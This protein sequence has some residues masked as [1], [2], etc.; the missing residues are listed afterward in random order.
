MLQK[1]LEQRRESIVTKWIEQLINSYEPE[2]IRFLKREK[3][4][5]ANPVRST[6][7]SSIGKLYDGILSGKNLTE[8]YQGLEEIIKLRAVQ[9][10]SP[11]KAL[12]FLFD[13]KKIVRDE[14]KNDNSSDELAQDLYVLEQKIDSVVG[15][16]FDIYTKYRNK[17]YEIRL[18]EIKSQSQRAFE[19]LGRQK[20]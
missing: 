20:K 3:N 10:F 17:I 2:M 11:A 19:I 15:L 4:Q 12:S 13:L 1:L 8:Y 5:F 6:I 18:A 16:A 14:L 9:E 7:V